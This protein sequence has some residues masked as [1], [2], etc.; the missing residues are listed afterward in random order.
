MFKPYFR[1]LTDSEFHCYLVGAHSTIAGFAFGLFILFGVTI[2]VFAP[3][4]ICTITRFF[5]FIA[6][7]VIRYAYQCSNLSVYIKMLFETDD[8]DVDFS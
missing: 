3:L 8:H 1:L 6:S 2:K 4:S 5:E 7:F